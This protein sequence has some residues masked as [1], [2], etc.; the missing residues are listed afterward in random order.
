MQAGDKVSWQYVNG[1]ASGVLKEKL[2]NGNWYVELPDG[3]YVI[4]NEL[5][6]VNV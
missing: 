3:R 1:V 2:D 6:F 4:V 5:I